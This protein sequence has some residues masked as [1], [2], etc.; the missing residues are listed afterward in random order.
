MDFLIAFIIFLASMTASVIWNFSMLIPLVI[1]Y[2]AFSAVAIHRGLKPK[3][4]V[5]C[6]ARGF[7][8][9]FIVIIVMLC[10]GVLTAMWRAGGTILWFVYYGVQIITPHV[11]ILVAFLLCAIL[12][13]ALG[14]SFGVAGTMG[15]ILMTIGAASGANLVLTGGAIMSGIYF[16]DR[17]SYASSSAILTAMLTETDMQKNVPM[18]LKTGWIPIG[19]AAVL[20]GVLSYFY[21]MTNT[22]TSWILTSITDDY[23]ISWPLVVP[24]LIM[25]ILP[26]FR[27][28]IWL[29]MLIS[30]GIGFIC[31][32]FV[33]GDSAL[34]TLIACFAGVTEA[35]GEMGQL[36]LGG[37][38]ISM[39]E[40][41]AI[42]ILSCSYSEIFESADMLKSVTE[43]MEKMIG[44][45][46]RFLSTYIIGIASCA[47]F[48]NQTI[49]DIVTVNVIG[50]AHKASG[51]TPDEFAMDIE[52]SLILS[53]GIVPWCLA[54]KVPLALMGA[55]I[56]SVPFAFSLYFIPIYYYFAKKRFFKESK[57]KL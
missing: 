11:F 36:L 15:Y 16:G 6:T 54:C 18:M 13:Y 41:S 25:F 50:K 3:D 5:G 8:K 32:V 35:R 47:I 48:C 33:Q 10:I 45:L 34:A 2:F 14:T 4:I 37:G 53:A 55:G 19:S 27:L 52:N 24:A 23:N 51:G 57:G 38:M 1:G 46:G 28:P 30:A 7:K 56:S 9:G 17:C 49:G 42:L 44:R 40:V 21:P 22:D 12:S 31:A 26:L 43:K 29:T 20:Y 39:V